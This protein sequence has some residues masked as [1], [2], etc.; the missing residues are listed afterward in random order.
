MKKNRQAPDFKQI[1]TPPFENQWDSYFFS[2]NGVMIFTL[3][4]HDKELLSR[5]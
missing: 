3:L 5:I 4:T 1:Y 2:S